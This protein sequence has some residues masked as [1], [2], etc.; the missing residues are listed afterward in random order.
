MS[1]KLKKPCLSPQA[2]IPGNGTLPLEDEQRRLVHAVV[3]AVRA[4]VAEVETHHR[5]CG[6]Y[7]MVLMRL[8]QE[9]LAP[10]YWLQAGYVQF[11]TGDETSREVAG[12]HPAGIGNHDDGAGDLYH[13]WVARKH[14]NGRIEMI[15]VSLGF[16]PAMAE[17]VGFTWQRQDF[18]R[19]LWTWMDEVYFG[20]RWDAQYMTD[21]DTMRR[22]LQGFAT[23]Q[24][25][26]DVAHVVQNARTLYQHPGMVLFGVG[27]QMP[28][29][30]PWGQIDRYR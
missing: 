18:P 21:R 2:P 14:A 20:G 30:N 19:Y 23:P 26:E 7:A 9:V 17:A 3:M 27:G 28:A 12:V 8:L 22:I 6:L 4:G 5:I 1:W 29:D 15:D 13:A 24:S 10:D 11:G 16:W 25:R